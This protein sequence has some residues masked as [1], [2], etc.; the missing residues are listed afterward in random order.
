MKKNEQQGISFDKLILEKVNFTIDPDYSFGGEPLSVKMS[1]SSDKTF[2]A[3]KKQ[4][5]FLLHANIDLAGVDP[6][7]MKVD[8]A[9]AGHFSI[10][11]DNDPT[12]LKEFSDVQAPAMLFPFIR[13]IV[14]NLTMRTDFPP[15]LIPPA[16]IRVLIGKK[17]ESEKVKKT[18]T[19]KKSSK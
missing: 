19:K 3:T 1:F 2:S 6:S 16:N 5:K 10:T 9:V 15:L 4:L 7:P 12:I 17:I 13:E 11:D 14:G 8:V 18:A